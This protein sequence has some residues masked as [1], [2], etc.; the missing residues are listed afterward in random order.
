MNGNKLKRTLFLL[1]TVFILCLGFFVRSPRAQ[2]VSDLKLEPDQVVW[3]ALLFQ[4][5]SFFVTVAIE[6]RL[7]SLCSDEVLPSLMP[8]PQG[9]QIEPSGPTIHRLTVDT[10]IDPLFGATVR[11]KNQIWFDPKLASALQRIRLRRGQDDFEKTCRFTETGVYRLRREPLGKKEV[12][13]AP[14]QWT[15][16][17]ASFYPYDLSQTGCRCVSES[18]IIPYI[19]AAGGLS[20]QSGPTNLCVFHKKLLHQVQLVSMGLESVEVDY[21]EKAQ[22]RVT[23]KQGT[24]E[25]MNLGLRARALNTIPGEDESFSFLGLKGEIFLLVDTRSGVPVQITGDIPTFGRVDFKLREV[26]LSGKGD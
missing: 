18:S 14:D 9:L 22:Q 5:D 21:T 19:I 13:L 20:Q 15:D 7:A 26:W 11:L 23:P 8:S 25:V 6:V 1:F 16:V 4:A 12:L 17:K 24:L 3:T 2:T 10:T